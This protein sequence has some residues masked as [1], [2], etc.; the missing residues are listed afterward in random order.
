[1]DPGDAVGQLPRRADDRAR[2]RPARASGSP[3]A[4]RAEAEALGYTVVDAESRPRHP[5]DRDDP[6]HARRPAHAPGRQATCSTSSRSA[7]PPSS[8]RSSPTCSRSASCSACCRRCSREGVSIR[9]LGAIVEA[10]G[11][12]A[13]AHARPGAAGRVR[14]PGARPHDRRAVPRRRRSTLRAIALDPGARAGGRRRDRPDRRRR[15]PR[16]GPVARAGFGARLRELRSSTRSRGAAVR[17]CCARRACAA[18]CAGSC[19]QALPQLAVCSYNEIAPGSVWRPSECSA[20]ADLP[21]RC[22]SPSPTLA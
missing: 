16:D 14:A 11:D 20:R 3:T 19:E 21:I 1:M 5:P 6:R 8:R 10:V 7:T 17:C 2:L 15:V 12:K 22:L 18:T 13:R 4:A 9:D